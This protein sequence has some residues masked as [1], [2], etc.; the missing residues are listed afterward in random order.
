MQ[1][2]LD[3]LYQIL[4]YLFDRETLKAIFFWPRF[5]IAS[6][7][8]ALSLFRLGIRPRTVIDVGA[9]TG[10]FTIAAARIFKG[11]KIHAFEPLPNCVKK[12]RRL[13]LNL[14]DVEIHAVAIGH[15]R[16][17]CDFFVN[18]YSQ[19]SSMLRLSKKKS[20]Q[21]PNLEEINTIHIDMETLDSFFAERCMKGPVLLKIDVQGSE[22]LVLEGAREMLKRIDYVL[23]EASF[24]PTYVG[25]PLFP[26]LFEIMGELSFGFIRPI[27]FLRHPGSG[28]ILQADVLFGRTDG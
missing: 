7:S 8:N 9:N 5:S 27:N 13:T 24:T 23:L 22:K 26:E 14:P 4:P 16:G 25:E 12:L 28:E 10:Q 2:L 21:F 18:A 3:K 17:K 20:A 6:Y 1:K 15:R 11:A 19:A